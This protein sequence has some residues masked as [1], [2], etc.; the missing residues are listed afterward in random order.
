M[1][2][3]NNVWVIADTHFG[4]GMLVRV[5]HRP[6]GFEEL[7]L[8]NLKEY[9]KED[10]VLI[11]LGDV[12]LG[13]VE[14]LSPY[15]RVRILVKGNHDSRTDNTYYDMGFTAVCNGFL[16]ERFG[17]RVWFSHRPEE[18]GENIDYN[19][20]GHTH[21]KGEPVSDKHIPI[22]YEGTDYKPHN[23]RDLVEG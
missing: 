23:L 20:H 19:I 11:H 7:I 21:G 9:I 1:R 8:N 6:E 3:E 15:G 13:R 22:Y 16:F 12:E 5:G 14:D 2:M 17:K 4:H 10:D 18:I